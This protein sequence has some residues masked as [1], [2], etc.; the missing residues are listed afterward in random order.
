MSDII[1]KFKP[2]GHKAL[3][4]AIKSL[5]RATGK[6]SKGGGIFSTTHKRN[7]KTMGIFGNSLSTVRSKLLLYNF[8]MAMGVSQTVAFA[9]EAA[10]LK[11]LE[12]AFDGLREGSESAFSAVFKLEAATK[13]TVSQF[14]LLKQANN[15][16]VL[17]ITKN[18]DEMAEMFSLAKRLGDA[19]GIDTT[20]AVESLTTG[21]GRQS[22]L[23]LDNIGIIVDTEKA[24]KKYAK[25]NDISV[26]SMSDVQ[27]KQAFLNETMESARTKVAA[28]GPA[29]ANA[30]DSFN[31]FS[32]AMQNLSHSIGSIFG[33]T[34]TGFLDNVVDFLGRMERTNLQQIVFS[35]EEMGVAISSIEG[36]NEALSFEQAMEDMKEARKVF[37]EDF[38]SMVVTM[39]AFAKSSNLT[40]D[41]VTALGGT[42]LDSFTTIPSAVM[43]GD[44]PNVPT[45]L[46]A[47]RASFGDIS[48][49]SL[50]ALDIE[51]AKV[52]Q[53]AQVLAQESAQ[54]S[55]SITDNELALNNLADTTTDYAKELEVL[56]L[57]D[58]DLLDKN[59]QLTTNLEGQ[60]D[61]LVKMRSEVKK[62]SSGLN[63]L[64]KTN[65]NLV[66]AVGGV[67]K[68]S[69]DVS[70]QITKEDLIRHKLN[71]VIA[72]KTALVEQDTKTGF[73]SK[74]AAAEA[75]GDMKE[76][77]IE[78][79]QLTTQL[80]EIKKRAAEE[81][82][83]I[84]NHQMNVRFQAAQMAIQTFNM[85]TQAMSADLAEREAEALEH[86]KTTASYQ[87]ASDEQRIRMEKEASL[88]FLSEK[89]KIFRMEQA[90]S[91]ASIAM[92]TSQAIMQAMATFPPPGNLVWAS[93]IGAMGL[94]QAGTVLAQ[95]PPKAQYGGYIAGNRHSEG[96]TLIEAERGEFIMSRNAV[97]SIGLEKINEM[98]RTGD[99]GGTINV[100]VSGNVMTQD[101]VEGEL[102][103]SIKEAVRRGSDFGV[104]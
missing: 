90:S 96:G 74:E 1:V 46:E 21:I 44:M 51:I 38:D 99:A 27:K 63:I 31:R 79:M 55:L 41:Q 4:E 3:I 59:E 29:Q 32:A 5:D 58:I 43:G 45:L 94:V 20:R 73:A 100:N 103:E 34:I 10:K 36:L 7:A 6:A 76:L 15:A 52:V 14:D 98:D 33:P 95:S 69:I 81:E 40:A 35:L 64:T 49:I 102:A 56:I 104:S 39:D 78:E 50:D 22:R 42:L 24:Y 62:Y 53:T 65:E 16:M 72:K 26:D 80:S 54:A 70:E 23:M 68:M 66:S 86:L 89:K 83:R 60:L 8:A 30:A 25:A 2:V 12:T 75:A 9:K 93:I 17:G 87:A 19:V 18:T 84:A 92:N 37:E 47:V 11:N 57:K 13:G 97:K 91:I 88:K 101:F 28:L 77:M 82:A 48:A 71:K 61:T 85:V 67:F